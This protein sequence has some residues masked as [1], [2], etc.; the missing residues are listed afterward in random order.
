MLLLA[1]A[2]AGVTA[3]PAPDPQRA[4]RAKVVRIAARARPGATRIPIVAVPRDRNARY[5]LTDLPSEKVDG[6]NL[7][8]RNTGMACGVVGAPVCPSK[9][10]TLVTAPLD[11][12][13]K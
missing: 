4:R 10:K 8:V 11:A 5:R 12:T 1:F 13:D 3:A 9:G 2:L 6:K 7:A